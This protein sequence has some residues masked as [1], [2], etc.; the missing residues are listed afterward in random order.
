VRVPL[1]GRTGHREWKR[2]R[3]L[4]GSVVRACALLLAACGTAPASQVGSSVDVPAQGAPRGVDNQSIVERAAL[5]QR[6]RTIGADLAGHWYTATNWFDTTAISRWGEAAGSLGIDCQDT[7]VAR[8]IGSGYWPPFM[9]GEHWAIHGDDVDAT[10]WTLRGTHSAGSSPDESRGR[11]RF[12]RSQPSIGWVSPDR[13]LTEQP[14][15]DAMT[16]CWMVVAP[17]NG[18]LVIIPFYPESTVSVLPYD[19][20]DD[21][22]PTGSLDDWP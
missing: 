10:G 2:M 12:A 6:L 15:P 4:H 19:F 22:A 16:G 14:S 8:T 18:R 5:A 9:I 1:V 7:M 13:L 17:G 11:L 20:D 21:L 3:R